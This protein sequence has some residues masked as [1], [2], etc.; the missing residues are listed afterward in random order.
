MLPTKL[1]FGDGLKSHYISYCEERVEQMDQ[2]PEH[3]SDPVT[4]ESI[5][6]YHI[7]PHSTEGT[8]NMGT[9]VLEF[10]KS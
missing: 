5:F 3:V 7:H 6:H 2:H 10:L 8:A 1:P 4:E 9:V